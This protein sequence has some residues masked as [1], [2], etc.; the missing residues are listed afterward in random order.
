MRLFEAVRQLFTTDTKPHEADLSLNLAKAVL[1]LETAGADEQ[2][3]AEEKVMLRKLLLA[4][5][6]TEEEIEALLIEAKKHSTQHPDL[7]H[8][9]RHIHENLSPEDRKEL[10]TQIWMVVL[11]DGE[12]SFEEDALTRKLVGLFRLERTAW[13]ETKNVAQNRIFDL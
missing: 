8:Y 10:L 9:T 3:T 4:D 13:L 2:T 5:G 7:F 6:L 12:I 1:L 11:S